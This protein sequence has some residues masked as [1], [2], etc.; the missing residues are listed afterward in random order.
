MKAKVI[1]IWVQVE[2]PCSQCGQPIRMPEFINL[3][4]GQIPDEIDYT[5]L[6]ETDGSNLDRGRCVKC[7]NAEV[8]AA[9]KIARRQNEI[10]KGKMRIAQ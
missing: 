10:R 7:H 6:K 3:V 1:K 5:P 2:Y 9:N 4:N 8:S